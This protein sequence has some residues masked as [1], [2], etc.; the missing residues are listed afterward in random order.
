MKIVVLIVRILMGVAFLFFGLNGVLNFIPT[1]PL[2]PGL[3]KDFS[4]VMAASHYMAAVGVVEIIASLL[5]LIN[6]FV[7]LALVLA[8]GKWLVRGL[9]EGVRR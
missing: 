6:R 7:P 8:S 9:A 2:P 5:L 4:T 3:M 1:P